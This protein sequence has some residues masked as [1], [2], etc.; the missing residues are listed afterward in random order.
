MITYIAVEGDPDEAAV[1][2]LLKLSDCSFQVTMCL[3]RKG[4]D[5][6]RSKIGQ[7]NKVAF[8]IHF[9]ILI[10]LNSGIDC[11]PN[12]IRDW[13]PNP[14]PKMLLRVAVRELEAW[15]LADRGNFAAFLGV[16]KNRIPHYPETIE[17]PKEFVVNLARRSRRREILED[18]VPIAGST[19]RVGRNYSGKLIEFI[20]NHW[21]LERARINAPSLDKAIKALMDCQQT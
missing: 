4:K 13:L 1:R 3:G 14:A 18:I 16:P 15:L 12:L 7:F 10:D 20:E 8:K 19:S 11:A 6:I 2:K 5:Y 21:D 17:Y 9:F